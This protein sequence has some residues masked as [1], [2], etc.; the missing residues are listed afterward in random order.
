MSVPRWLR[1]LWHSATSLDAESKPLQLPDWVD[2]ENAARRA[3]EYEHATLAGAIRAAAASHHELIESG[4]RWGPIPWSPSAAPPPHTQAQAAEARAHNHEMHA[5]HGNVKKGGKKGAPRKGVRKAARKAAVPR[6]VRRVVAAMAAAARPVQHKG[7]R[8]SRSRRGAISGASEPSFAAIS[9]PSFHMVT[10]VREVSR[11]PNSLRMEGFVKI[12]VLTAPSGS[13]D[14]GTVLMAQYVN[15]AMFSGS[16][17]LTKQFN[18]FERWKINHLEFC[19]MPICSSGVS[20]T[21]LMYVESDPNDNPGQGSVISTVETAN[22]FRGSEN[23]LW[24]ARGCARYTPTHDLLY[25]NANYNLS[26]TSNVDMRLSA[27]GVLVV[28]AGDAWPSSGIVNGDFAQL[29]ARLSFEFHN[30]TET[31]SGMNYM[32]WCALPYTG[33]S[34]TSPL[35]WSSGESYASLTS[36]VVITSNAI[37]GPAAGHGLVE[38]NTD[39]N[40]LTMV[41]NLPGTTGVVNVVPGTY[42]LRAVMAFDTTSGVTATVDEQHPGWT[43]FD[44][45]GNMQCT[46]MIASGAAGVANPVNVI[47]GASVTTPGT[48]AAGD[49]YQPYP[50]LFLTTDTSGTALFRLS[51]SGNIISWESLVTF[52]PAGN[53]GTPT[54]GLVPFWPCFK[55]DFA[56]WTGTANTIHVSFILVRMP[57]ISLLDTAHVGAKR[58]RPHFEPPTYALSREPPI[59]EGDSKAAHDQADP[60][61]GKDEVKPVAAQARAASQSPARR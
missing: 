43:I 26:Y 12:G 5:A 8:P 25:T 60:R 44:N 20:G 7:P 54:N 10:G 46:P 55:N 23:T 21:Y 18:T 30:P 28:A 47:M 29:Y 32:K 36:A 2:S 16:A 42:L 14:P 15:A 58:A 13:V 48:G 51:L 34:L 24:G 4:Y 41:G 17:Q 38:M 1:R 22:Q 40:A 50:E 45:T 3:R 52:N 53:S 19:T 31:P 37:G 56:T 49:F 33:A 35:S 39:P 6:P 59:I 11:S 9:Q 27:A 57:F 61:P